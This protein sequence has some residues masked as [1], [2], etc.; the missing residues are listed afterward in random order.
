MS[1]QR[2]IGLIVLIGGIVMLCISMYIKTQ[3]LAGNEQIASGEQK[4]NTVDKVFSFSPATKDFGSQVTKSGKAKIAKGKEEIAYY[5]ALANQLQVGGIVF[6][7]AGG[8]IFLFGK[9]RK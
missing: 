6:L 7:I 2:I 1:I 4:L 5:T 9:K 3:V 8:A